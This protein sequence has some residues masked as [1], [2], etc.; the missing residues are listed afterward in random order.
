MDLDR[1]RHSGS[2]D[3]DLVL[4]SRDGDDDAAAELVRRHIDAVHR[5]LLARG[6]DPEVAADLVQET[7]RRAVSS[8]TSI[9]DHRG[10]SLLPWLIT[11]AGNLV[12]DHFRSAAVAR[13][14]AEPPSPDLAA[15]DPGPEHALERSEQADAAAA[16][17][18]A[19][20]PSHRDV[21]RMRFLE[22]LTVQETADRLDRTYAATATL[23][24]RALAAARAMAGSLPTDV[25]GPAPPGRDATAPPA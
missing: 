21:L 3:F 5:F 25:S 10:G 17:L 11:V 12:R 6:R 19:L 8:L 9:E 20:S 2:N 22:G 24:S 7:F 13:R 1:A 14:A 23:Q 15:A 4:A 18:D 16:L